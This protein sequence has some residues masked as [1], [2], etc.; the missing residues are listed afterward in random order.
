MGPLARRGAVFAGF[1]AATALAAYALHHANLDAWTWFNPDPQGFDQELWAW[2]TAGA[3]AATAGTLVAQLGALLFGRYAQRDGAGLP[4][5]VAAGLG[6]ALTQL[7]VAVPRA[8]DRLN[9][10]GMAIEMARHGHPFDPALWRQPLVVTAVL[11]AVVSCLAWS[12]I[13]YGI[14]RRAGS[15]V[16]AVLGVLAV[17]LYVLVQGVFTGA[18]PWWAPAVLALAPCLA[19]VLL[20]RNSATTPAAAGT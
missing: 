18:G 20:S 13:G 5:A 19:A 11:A 17:L 9:G 8:V 14:G 4:T 2:L 1:A 10:K 6:L 12:I 15:V 3:F 7:A 16:H